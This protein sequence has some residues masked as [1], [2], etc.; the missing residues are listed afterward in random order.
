M[1]IMQNSNYA[2]K[3]L[4]KNVLN[5]V[6]PTLWKVNA[7]KQFKHNF[8]QLNV[9]SDVMVK[10]TSLSDPIVVTFPFLVEILARV[11]QKLSQI[12]RHKL[13]HIVN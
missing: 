8:N 13:M 9:V 2:V 7:I 4:K 1:I 3:Q 12:G 11:P 5:K 6:H 10:G